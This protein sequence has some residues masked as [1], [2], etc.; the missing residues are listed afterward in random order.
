VAVRRHQQT[1]DNV[2]AN[3]VADAKTRVVAPSA[4]RVPSR[5]P[6]SGT[7]DWPRRAPD[8][9]WAELPFTGLPAKPLVDIA[10]ALVGR[11]PILWRLGRPRRGHG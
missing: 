6:G 3:N 10:L 9:G 8:R 7:A 5:T 11:G 4:A 1:A 2:A